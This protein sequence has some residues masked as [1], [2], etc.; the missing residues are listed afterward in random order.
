MSYNI[1]EHQPLRTNEDE[2]LKE[3][4]DFKYL[5]S[6]VDSTEKDL[7]VRKVLAWNTTRCSGLSRRVWLSF[8]SATVGS[9]WLCSCTDAPRGG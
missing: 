6:Y 7:K 3:E 9:V 5:G 8:F 1:H 2:A 4:G